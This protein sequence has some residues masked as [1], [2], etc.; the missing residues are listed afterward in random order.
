MNG[1]VDGRS[2]VRNIRPSIFNG[3]SMNFVE[4]NTGD[5]VEL[6]L[7]QI[8]IAGHS[9]IPG[10]DRALQSAKE[11]VQGYAEGIAAIHG[12]KRFGYAGDGGVFMFRTGKG[13]GVD[14]MV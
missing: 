11:T 10:T 5:R 6:A 2:H 14:Q 4:P 13:E 7:L 3:V 1:D 8:D 9:T 12:G